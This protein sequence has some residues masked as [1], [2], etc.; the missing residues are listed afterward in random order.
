MQ[1][2]LL[3]FT[4]VLL[5]ACNDH[6]NGKDDVLEQAPFQSISDSISKDP[7]NAALYYR[8]GSL[9]YGKDEKELAGKDLWMAWNLSPSETH[10]LSLTTWLKEKSADSAILFLENAI[11]K[12]PRSIALK[13]GLARGYQQKGQKE[14]AISILDDIIKEY[15]GQLDALSLKSEILGELDQPEESLLYLEKAQS[16][17]P[18]DPELAFNLAY[19]YAMAKNEKVLRLT[20]SL[21]KALTPEIE[22]AFYSRGLYFSRT[23]NSR[24]AISNFDAAIKSNYNFLDAYHDKGELLFNLSRY[25]DAQRNFELALKIAPSNAL[26]YYWLGKCQE[27][28]GFKQEARANYL[29]AFGLDKTLVVAK[30]A[31]EKL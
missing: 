15:P 30:E 22:K 8:R 26:F 12:L 23:G 9:L 19:A 21:I 7:G 18:S 20:D 29:R 3:V 31:A 2:W 5:T 28:R 4:F 10:G 16:L 27:A 24:E 17:D 13:I 25:D 6:T 14:K 11:K 1:K